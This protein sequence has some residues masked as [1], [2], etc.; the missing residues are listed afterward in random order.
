MTELTVMVLRLAFFALLWIFVFL[1]AGVL[2]QDIFGPRAKKVRRRNKG[3][4]SKNSRPQSTPV[5]AAPASG[6][7]VQPGDQVTTAHHAQVVFTAGALQGRVIPL[8]GQP[9]TMGRAGGND[10]VLQDDF[11]SGVHARVV[12]DDGLWYIEDLGSTN[13]TFVGDRRLHG[14]VPLPAFTPVRIGNTTM[15]LQA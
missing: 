5:A 10:V 15:E 1:V 2:R 14:A 6:G 7:A 12:A 8:N 11:A 9:V 13:G 3:G 4:R